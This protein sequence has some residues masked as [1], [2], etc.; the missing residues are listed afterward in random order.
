MIPFTILSLFCL[1]VVYG[2]IC[3]VTSYK[4]PNVVSYGLVGLFAMYAIATWGTLP[5]LMHVGIGLLV[6]VMCIVFWQLGWLGGGDVKFVAAISLWMGPDK[7]FIFMIL[8][9]LASAVFIAALKF[10]YQWNAWFQGSTL[11]A[12]VKL[13]LTKSAE[14]AIPYGLPAA[15][16][17]IICTFVIGQP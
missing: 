4:I 11:P 2:A 5:L 7:I 6:F 12:F 16:S 15:I 10:L 1:L 8:L 13:M 14:R 3:D 9:T 17:A